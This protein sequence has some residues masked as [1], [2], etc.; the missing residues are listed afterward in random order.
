MGLIEER[1]VTASPS[2]VRAFGPRDAILLQQVY[3]LTVEAGFGEATATRTEL[4]KTTGLTVDQV[5]RSVRKLAAAGVLEA[6]EMD[7]GNPGRSRQTYTVDETRVAEIVAN[8]GYAESPESTADPGE[9][10]QN[11][12]HAE[13]HVEHAKSPVQ[14]A[15]SHKRTCEIAHPSSI[16]E[17]D[18]TYQEKTSNSAAAAA[19]DT[20]TVKPPTFAEFWSKYPNKRGKAVAE[21]H[22]KRLTPDHRRM[23]VDRLPAYVASVD[24]Q[25]LKHGSTYVSQR[26]WL[27]FEETPTTPADELAAAAE[28]NRRRQAEAEARRRAQAEREKWVMGE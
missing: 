3:W 25:F 9:N 4:A 17:S 24:P 1:T 23:A 26:V 27:D 14:H 8:S 5:A 13:S 12:G 6:T 15:K 18:T 22:W 19:Q 2:L 10:G 7:D 21:R 16:Q 11:I 28:R 20:E